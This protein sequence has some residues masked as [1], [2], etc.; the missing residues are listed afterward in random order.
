MA[1]FQVTL[2]SANTNYNV[3][4]LVR[5]VDANFVDRGMQISLQSD[6][7]NTTGQYILGGQDANVSAT[8]YGW[9]LTPG[10][11]WTTPRFTSLAGV[12]VRSGASGQK[13]N[14]EVTR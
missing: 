14:V 9:A 2:T 4:T 6:P 3:L 12:Y 13:L 10:D 1:S 11:S 7:T 8:R 5:A